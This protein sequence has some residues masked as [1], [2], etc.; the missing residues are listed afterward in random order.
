[1][2]EF[3]LY[4]RANCAHCEQLRFALELIQNS[5]RVAHF[6]EYSY[7]DVDSDAALQEKYGLS[8]PVLI[9]DSN[10]ICEGV[11]D[12]ENLERDLLAAFAA[13]S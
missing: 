4:G 7:V 13:A 5:G 8:V 6:P 9:H 10:T 11:F 12:I 3:T 1:M 2:A